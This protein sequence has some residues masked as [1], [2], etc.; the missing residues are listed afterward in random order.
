MAWLALAGN[1]ASANGLWTLQKLHTGDAE[2]MLPT[3]CSFSMSKAEQWYII[4]P[5]FFTLTIQTA[6]SPPLCLVWLYS[7]VCSSLCLQLRICGSCWRGGASAWAFFCN[8]SSKAPLVCQKMCL[9]SEK[10][11]HHFWLF[12]TWEVLLKHFRRIFSSAVS[13]ELLLCLSEFWQWYNKYPGPDGTEGCGWEMSV[14]SAGPSL[15]AQLVSV[16]CLEELLLLVRRTWSSISSE[17]KQREW[18]PA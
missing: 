18:C 6:T 11:I 16:P 5:Q 14:K 7:A 4:L 17:G 15:W 3:F 12:L 2:F 9:Y 1:T 13:V 10:Y 8:L